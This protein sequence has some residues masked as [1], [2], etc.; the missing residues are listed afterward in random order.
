MKRKLMIL[1]LACSVVFGVTGCA[2]K[3]DVAPAT[4]ETKTA[5]TKTAET[6]EA[7]APDHGDL[8][9]IGEYELKAGEYLF[10]FG[11]APEATLDI[12]ILNM[13]GITDLEHEM[14]HL[15]GE[16]KETMAQDAKFDLEPHH[17]Y[18]LEMNTEEDHGHV[19]FT[20][21]ED[22]VYAIG[23]EHAPAEFTM[24][25]FH[26]DGDEFFPTKEHTITQE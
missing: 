13:E 10:H 11:E 4:T 22:G 7:P 24:Q 19:Y 25:I 3:E 2:K 20:I 9:W 16:E 26:V 14:E 8:E 12:G 23:T 15:M 18:T 21:T 17:A 1:L 6:T 5:E